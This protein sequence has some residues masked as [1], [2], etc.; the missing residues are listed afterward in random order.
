MTGPVEPRTTSADGSPPLPSDRSFGFVFTGFFTLVGLW[1]VWKQDAP[2]WWAFGLA[3][4]LALLSMVSPRVLRPFNRA[5][6][7]FGAFM[8]GIVSPIILGFLYFGV[9]TPMGLFMR[10]VGKRPLQPQEGVDSYWVLRQP[11][12]PEGGSLRH[13]F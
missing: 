10:A 12:G 13:P 7:A 2:W 5:W 9:F 6:M 11:P 4:V 8:H 1:S 3:G